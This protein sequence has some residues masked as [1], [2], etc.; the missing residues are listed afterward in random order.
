M[1]VAFVAC[2][3]PARTAVGNLLAEKVAFFLDR[4][5][6][7]RIFLES[8][9][10]LHPQLTSHAERCPA[11]TT[12]GPA[13][14]YLAKSDLVFFEYSQG[15][16]LLGLLPLLID[17]RPKLIATYYGVSPPQGW[18]APQRDILERGHRERGLLWCA[19][20]V[21]TLSRFTSDELMRA[22]ELP[23]DRLHQHRIPLDLER[24]Q[25]PLSQDRS[26]K[27]KN[28]VLL[29][30]GRLAPN[31]RLPLVIEALADLPDA[32]TWI[33]GNSGDVYA[34]QARQVRDLAES[35]GVAS[36]VRW[37]GDVAEDA[38][39]ALYQQASVLVLPSIHEGFGI[40]VLEA[41]AAGLPV[42]AAR[43]TALP[44]T[45]GDAG[46]TFTVDNRGDFVRQLWRFPAQWDPKLGIHVT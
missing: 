18:P 4:G 2:S 13:W 22:I 37:L 11:G 3:A 41:Q 30:V 44:E 43:T 33:V 36:R 14:D 17:E 26:A 46:L 38:L 40:P 24:W 8:I 5:A 20:A 31:K 7:T 32:E 10:S 6:E 15:F 12:S 25:P 39:P 45:I 16:D 35:L 34:D 27:P 23:A 42:V 21:V 1:R 9:A 28:P 29:Y 19:D